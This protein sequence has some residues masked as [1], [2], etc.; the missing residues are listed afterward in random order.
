MWVQL[1][2]VQSSIHVRL[3]VT[4]WT[5]KSMDSPG[6]NTGVGSLSLLQGIFP[7]Q[8]SNRGLLHCRRISLPAEPPGKPK[9]TGGGSLSLL[10]WIFLSKC[11]GLRGWGILEEDWA[12]RVESESRSVVSDSLWP[13][14]LYSPWNSPGPNTGV[15]SL[16]LL[17]GIFPTQG[18]N[19]GLP[20]CRQ[21]LYQLSHRGNPSTKP[22]MKH[23]PWWLLHLL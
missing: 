8:G 14:G 3:F 18:M 9:N 6:Q 12:M 23:L 2:S 1:I 22:M 7:T 20:H 11:D 5:I 21:I 16:S 15:G 10:H 19:Q 4:P 17:Q 13:Q